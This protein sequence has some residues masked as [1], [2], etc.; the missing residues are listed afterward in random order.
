MISQLS[1]I[2]K[3]FPLTIKRHNISWIIKI[4][5]KILYYIIF[6]I[7]LCGIQFSFGALNKTCILFDSCKS[8][9][10]VKALRL[11]V[12]YEFLRNP[13]LVLL[14]ST[15]GKI[16]YDIFQLILRKERIVTST[17]NSKRVIFKA[18][19]TDGFIWYMFSLQ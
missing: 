15:Y 14:R 8:K 11:S 17:N 1:V 7:V 18:N 5:R 3:I 10:D 13:I 4:W 19:S 12:S 9:F 2:C 16:Q 6:I